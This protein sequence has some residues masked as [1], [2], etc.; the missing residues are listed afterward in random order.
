MKCQPSTKGHWLN[1]QA[2]VLRAV[3][4]VPKK[5]AVKVGPRAMVKATKAAFGPLNSEELLEAEGE[6]ESLISLKVAEL[7]S[8][9]KIILSLMGAAIPL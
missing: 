5:Y 1:H 6:A 4:R 2:K 9:G 3:A 7:R 8:F